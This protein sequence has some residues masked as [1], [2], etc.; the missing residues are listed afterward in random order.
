MLV[1]GVVTASSPSQIAIPNIVPSNTFSNG[2]NFIA[3]AGFIIDNV[4]V[5]FIP[6]TAKLISGTTTATG[7]TANFTGTATP[8]AT[9]TYT[10]SLTNGG[11]NT[12]PPA[13]ANGNYSIPVPLAFGLNVFTVTSTDAFGRIV[14]IQ[15]PTVTPLTSTLK[16][17]TTTTVS[18]AT[19][20]GTASPGATVTYTDS[21]PTNG[22]PTPQVADSMGNYTINP[23]L[24]LG[25]NTFTVTTSDNFKLVSQQTV[26]R[27]T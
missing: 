24:A 3:R 18:P 4:P 13:D 5:S 17:S 14:A 21:I 9:V 8:G 20:T 2:A 27:T 7:G 11:P 25:A 15:T 23:P 12:S 22:G 10:D 26:T 6:L 19:F 16:S 1:N